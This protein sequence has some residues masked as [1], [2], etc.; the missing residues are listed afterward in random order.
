MMIALRVR[1]IPGAPTRSAKQKQQKH[2]AINITQDIT[3]NSHHTS[4]TNNNDNT[5]NTDDTNNTSNSNM[6]VIMKHRRGALG[7]LH[8]H[9]ARLRPPHGGRRPLPAA[10][11]NDN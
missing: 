9:V 2:E 11:L 3:T 8:H 7:P 10:G 6:L 1:I 4:N 5:Y